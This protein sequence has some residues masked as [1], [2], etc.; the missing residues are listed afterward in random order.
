MVADGKGRSRDQRADE[1]LMWASV[2]DA[3]RRRRLRQPGSEMGG[4]HA[5]STPEAVRQPPQQLGRCT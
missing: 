5:R 4:R 2:K 1:R 3:R